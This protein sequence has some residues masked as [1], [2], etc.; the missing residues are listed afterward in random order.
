[1][2]HWPVLL[3]AASAL[4]FILVTQEFDP[5]PQV[6]AL[7]LLAVA[8]AALLTT[9]TCMCLVVTTLTMMSQEA[10][11]MRIIHC[12]GSFGVT[13]LPQAAG[14]RSGQKATCP[15]SWRPCQVNAVHLYVLL[16]LNQ[17]KRQQH[18]DLNWHLHL[19]GF[20]CMFVLLPSCFAWQQSPGVWRNW[21]PFWWKQRQWCA[22]V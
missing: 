7:H 15:Q 5:T 18:S 6:T 2:T 13:T 10:Q 19:K 21:D 1:M 3:T 8:T 9:Q 20:K 14:S 22:R 4:V 12:S 17:P 16:K 11:R